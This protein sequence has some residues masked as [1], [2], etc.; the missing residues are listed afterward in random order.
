MT[1]TPPQAGPVTPSGDTP[2]QA[3]KPQATA[4]PAPARPRAGIASAVGSRLAALLLG[5]ACVVWTA[6]PLPHTGLAKTAL[7]IAI[8]AVTAGALR[9]ATADIPQ[10]EDQFFLPAYLQAWLSFLFLLRTLAWEETAVVAIL[11]LEVQHPARPWPTAAL[12]AALLAYLLT[13]HIAESGADAGPLLRR[14]AKLLIAGACLLAIGAGFAMIPAGGPGAGSAVLRVIAAAAVIVA[15][16]L[17]L[18][19]SS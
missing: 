14:H 12:G 8:I 9:L 5:V 3:V 19:G 15:A 18:P 2:G 10:P 6:T 13:T 17:V 7:V 4:R 1:A 11:W 16:A